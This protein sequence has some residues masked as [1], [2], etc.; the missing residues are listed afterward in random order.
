MTI[1]QTVENRQEHYQWPVNT[2]VGNTETNG[3]PDV[4]GLNPGISCWMISSNFFPVAMMTESGPQEDE[5]R[6][7][8]S[9]PI[10]RLELLVLLRIQI[11]MCSPWSKRLPKEFPVESFCTH[12]FTLAEM[13]EQI[14]PENTPGLSSVSI[15][16]T[17]TQ[18]ITQRTYFLMPKCASNCGK[19]QF[20]EH[21]IVR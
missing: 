9:T 17:S 18:F 6:V 3:Q 4:V 20:Y 11:G 7:K 21:Y 19:E 2:T 1:G 8:E 13:C 14:P 15:W 12:C 10:V 16:G 5:D